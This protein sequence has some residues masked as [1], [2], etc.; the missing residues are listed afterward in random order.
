MPPV[1]ALLSRFRTLSEQPQLMLIL[2]VRLG[3]VNCRCPVRLGFSADRLYW[4]ER[5]RLSCSRRSRMT[6]SAMAGV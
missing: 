1:S 2:A 6:V 3:R 4:A 5:R